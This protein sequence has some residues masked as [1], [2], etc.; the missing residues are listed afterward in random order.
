MNGAVNNGAATM[1]TTSTVARGSPRLVVAAVNSCRE[2][3]G[4]AYAWPAEEAEKGRERRSE[5]RGRGAAEA[6]GG[7]WRSAAV[8]EGGSRGRAKKEH[9]TNGGGAR[10]GRGAGKGWARRGARIGDAVV[11]VAR[12]QKRRPAAMRA[13]SVDTCAYDEGYM[14]N[15]CTPSSSSE[16]VLAIGYEVSEMSA[17]I[18]RNVVVV[19]KWGRVAPG[20]PEWTAGA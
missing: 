17:S 8:A 13:G 12:R 19:L 3:M 1:V 10:R 2:R 20:R 11:K 6:S 9:G 18:N 4:R 7:A 5:R 14:V 15:T 16:S